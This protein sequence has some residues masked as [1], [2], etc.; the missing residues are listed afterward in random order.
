MT[1]TGCL[2]KSLKKTKQKTKQVAHDTQEWTDLQVTKVGGA[3]T[4]KLEDNF[5]AYWSSDVQWSEPSVTNDDG[6]H[7][8]NTTANVS[9]G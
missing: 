2:Y 8:N 3:Q 9:V 5:I 1:H 7:E 6:I 4:A